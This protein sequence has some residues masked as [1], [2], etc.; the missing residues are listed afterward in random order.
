M[1]IP[2]I[3]HGQGVCAFYAGGNIGLADVLRHSNAEPKA[4][5][6]LR[7]GISTDVLV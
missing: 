2:D 6:E 4:L 1:Y 3:V 7:Y 5:L